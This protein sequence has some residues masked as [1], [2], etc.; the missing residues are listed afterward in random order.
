[1]SKEILGKRI[2]RWV[3][4]SYTVGGVSISDIACIHSITPK[5][6]LEILKEEGIVK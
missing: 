2:R 5:E 1:M 6:V 3:V 4:K